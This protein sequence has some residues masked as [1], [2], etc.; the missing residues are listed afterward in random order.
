MDLLNKKNATEMIPSVEEHFEVLGRTFCGVVHLLRVT[1][2]IVF[3]SYCSAA[4]ETTLSQQREFLQIYVGRLN[5]CGM[6]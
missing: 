5:C 4:S 2:F 1:P 6:M 3:T